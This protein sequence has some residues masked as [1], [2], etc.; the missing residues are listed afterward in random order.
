[1]NNRGVVR[2]LEF[3]GAGGTFFSNTP[4]AAQESVT[5]AG[6]A[7]ITTYYTAWTTTGADALTLANGAQK[8]QLKKIQL[9]VDGG[10][11]GTLTPTTLTGGTT[12]TF[13]DAGDYVILA[14]DASSWVPIE[15]GNAADG[16]TAPVLA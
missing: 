5:A 15:L 12:I 1:M 14:W 10:S 11:D 9:I 6:A 2:L 3:G 4:L 16:A 8:G 13:A 7:S